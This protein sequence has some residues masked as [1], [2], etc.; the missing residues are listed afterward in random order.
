MYRGMEIHAAVFL[1]FP[2]LCQKVVAAADK[3]CYNK[4]Y[5]FH[6]FLQGGSL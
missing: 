4:D 1:F 5:D 6:F 3:C 2:V